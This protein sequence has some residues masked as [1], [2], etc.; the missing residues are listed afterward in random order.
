MTKDQRRKWEAQQGERDKAVRVLL[1]LR[2]KMFEPVGFGMA[3]Q[4]RKA[5]EAPEK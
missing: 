4:L 5:S 1:G 3:Q 2:D